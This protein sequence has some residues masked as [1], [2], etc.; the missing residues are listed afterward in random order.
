MFSKSPHLQCIA[1]CGV[2]LN[3]LLLFGGICGDPGVKK[4][5]YLHYTKA[6]FS[7]GK[8]VF[9]QDSDDEHASGEDEGD[10]IEQSPNNSLQKRRNFRTASLEKARNTRYYQPSWEHRE[11]KNGA[12]IKVLYCV[13]CNVD[14]DEDMEHCEDCQVC[15]Y[16][17][18]HHCV[19][20]SK[21][22]GGG[23]IYC[24]G[25]SI[26]MLVFNFI[27]LF[28]FLIIDGDPESRQ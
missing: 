12:K 26:G 6:W 5:T 25:G 17:Y 19:F 21:C 7:E 20:F 4:E 13:K 11:G 15:V 8:E 1:I 2:L 16:D 23:N 10:D 28:V 14:V 24:F 9:T 3:L 27:L 18:D 22:I